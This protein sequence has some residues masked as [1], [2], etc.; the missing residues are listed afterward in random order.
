MILPIAALLLQ[1]T[2]VSANTGLEASKAETVRAEL[3]DKRSEAGV[4][5]NAAAS[6]STTSP[7]LPSAPEPRAPKDSTPAYEAAEPR[8]FTAALP[9]SAPAS[10]SQSMPHD[11]SEKARHREWMALAIAEHSAAGFDAWS[12]RRA[13][14]TGDAQESNPMLRPFAGNPSIYAAIQIGPVLFDYVSRRM[15][16][17]E[18]GWARHTWWVL[19]AVSTATSLGS[20]AHN[21]T[22]H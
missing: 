21:L 7:D 4:D 12:T 18:H 10:F 20:G 9:L 11:R 19:Q 5:G 2:A 3:A 15:M 8:A 1:M 17:S 14:A 6:T 13:L 22:I 16:N